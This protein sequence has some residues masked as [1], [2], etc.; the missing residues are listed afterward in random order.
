M[1]TSTC[2]DR[3]RREVFREEGADLFSEN[4]GHDPA[5]DIMM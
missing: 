1:A 4:G 2:H 3:R 5:A